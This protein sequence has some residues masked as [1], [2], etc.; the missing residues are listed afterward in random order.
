MPSTSQHRVEFSVLQRE[1]VSILFF[2]PRDNLSVF[3]QHVSAANEYEMQVSSLTRSLSQ[4]EGQL[5]QANEDRVS[6]YAILV[7][8]CEGAA[9]EHFIGQNSQRKLRRK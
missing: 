4:M 7:C 2:L 5:R 1:G 6:E 8:D 9:S 3:L